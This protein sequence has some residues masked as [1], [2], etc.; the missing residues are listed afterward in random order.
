[1]ILD[2]FALYVVQLIRAITIF[3]VYHFH[4]CQRIRPPQ[5]MMWLTGG[6]AAAQ[7]DPPPQLRRITSY[8][9]EKYRAIHSSKVSLIVLE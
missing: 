8:L 5:K 2:S 9:L 4:S 3:T 7:I 6:L 1:M